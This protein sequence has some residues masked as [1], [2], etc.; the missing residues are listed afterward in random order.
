[1]LSALSPFSLNE[2]TAPTVPFLSHSQCALSARA[3][4]IVVPSLIASFSSSWQS[5]APVDQRPCYPFLFLSVW[6]VNS[7]PSFF[8]L[9][10]LCFECEPKKPTAPSFFLLA[11][12][13]FDRDHSNP[14]PCSSPPK[15]LTVPFFPS[16]L[17]ILLLMP[18]LSRHPPYT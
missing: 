5:G 14:R 15:L 3:V 18:I 1:M 9:A 12:L 10:P 8:L 11:P 17:L 6:S 2:A 13:C 16:F 4:E 7:A